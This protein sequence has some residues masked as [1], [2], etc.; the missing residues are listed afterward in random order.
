MLPKRFLLLVATLVLAACAPAPAGQA[1]SSVVPASPVPTR[2]ALLALPSATPLSTDTPVPS[3]TSV[4]TLGAGSTATSPI[5]SMV[6]DYVPAGSFLMGSSDS[7]G[8]AYADEKPQHPVTLEAFWIDQSEVTNGQYAL[9]MAA[10]VCKE[11]ARVSSNLH[12]QYYGNPVFADYPVMWVTWND[13]QAYCTWAGRRLPTE[14]E[15]EKAARGTDGRIYPWGDTP[16]DKTLAD[17]GNQIKD[18]NR[19]GSYPSGASPYGALDMAG[20]VWEWVADWYGLDYYSHSPDANPVGPD[21]GTQRVLRGGSY[22][23]TATGIRAAY[24]YQKEPT[25]KSSEVGFRCASDA[26]P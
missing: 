15:W 16:A 6:M 10:K 20:N 13:A 1:A 3:P 24:R 19:S 25:F 11:P 22:T 9:C 8:A 12:D 2:T 5:D 26:T 14:A 4:P 17:F 21:S 7:D 23:Y 18:V